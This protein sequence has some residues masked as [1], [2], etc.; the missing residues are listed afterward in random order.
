V[1]AWRKAELGEI[2][3][4]HPPEWWQDWARDPEYGLRWREIREHFGITGFG[5]NANEADSGRE[6]VVPHE[7]ASYGGQEELYFLVRGRARFTCGGENVELGPGDLLYV[8]AEVER[9]AVALEDSTLVY[10]VSGVPGAYREF[11]WDA[12]EAAKENP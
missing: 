2:G 3:H 1:P 5:V 4:G 10:M 7:E 9:E 11:D 6:L 8:P 12:W